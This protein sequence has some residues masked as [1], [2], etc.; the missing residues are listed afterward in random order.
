MDRNQIANVIEKLA[1]LLEADERAKIA[2][3]EQQ[4]EA[5]AQSVVTQVTDLLGDRLDQD[6]AQKLAQNDTALR[7]LEQLTQKKVAELGG[8][9]VS[10]KKPEAS[11]DTVKEA[12]KREHDA[13]TE[14][15]LHG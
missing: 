15:C 2:A 9:A 12:S 5:L 8:P 3:L 7:V 10:Q 14:W 13:F 4:K 11:K 6:T 1:D